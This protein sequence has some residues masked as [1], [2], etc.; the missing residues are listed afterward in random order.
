MKLRTNPRAVTFLDVYQNIDY[1]KEHYN[2][3]IEINLDSGS[4]GGGDALLCI[5]TIARCGNDKHGAIRAGWCREITPYVLQRL[6]SILCDALYEIQAEI[7]GGCRD[8][9]REANKTT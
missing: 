8:C 2:A 3:S 9:R 5:T 4:D 6:P 1:M 7:D